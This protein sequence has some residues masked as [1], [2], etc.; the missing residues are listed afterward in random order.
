MS[1][2]RATL[3][4]SDYFRDPYPTLAWLRENAPVHRLP[5]PGSDVPA[6]FVTRYADVRHV[7]ADRRFS[8]RQVQWAN[9]AF[10]DA[11]LVIGE[12]GVFQHAFTL[13]D[14]PDHTRVRRLLMPYFVPSRIAS[15]RLMIQDKVTRSL[16]AVREDSFDLIESFAAV[17]PVQVVNELLGFPA[18]EYAHVAG[19]VDRILPADPSRADATPDAFDEICDMSRALVL[20]KE[21]EPSDDLVSFLVK[22]WREDALSLDELT[23][24]VTSII[25][26]GIDSTRALIGNSVLALLRSPD[27]LDL[28]R[29]DP[30]LAAQAAE[31]FIRHSGPIM[32]PMVRFPVEDVEIDGRPVAVGTPVMPCV[33]AANRDP[34]FVVEPDRLDLRR[35]GARHLGLGYGMHNCLGAALARLEAAIAVPAVFRAF[36]SLELDVPLNELE[37]ANSLTL[38][39]LTRL[40]LRAV[41]TSGS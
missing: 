24:L 17:I 22:C 15:W 2:P 18:N 35:T 9:S 36:P 11:G 23:A 40:P 31:E 37:Y 6:V 41:Q 8:T 14:A 29:S 3:F 25:L 39:S 5:F 28:L 20:Q 33:L 1:E 32:V 26:G 21:R 7:L 4:S 13:Q 19:A 30:V 34:A 16:A 27:Q 12:S 10:R 38:R